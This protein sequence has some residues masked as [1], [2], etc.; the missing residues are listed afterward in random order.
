MYL[1]KAREY[2][3]LLLL[4]RELSSVNTLVIS[5]KQRKDTKESNGMVVN[6][7]AF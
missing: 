2:L 3:L 7:E 1:E 5:S 4:L 6:Q